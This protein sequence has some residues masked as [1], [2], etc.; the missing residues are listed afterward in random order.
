MSATILKQLANAH[1][2]VAKAEETLAQQRKTVS[3]LVR[4]GHDASMA[5]KSLR[6]SEHLHTM[7]I[8]ERYRLNK[9]LDENIRGSS[10]QPTLTQRRFGGSS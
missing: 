9:L 4:A 1:T 5:L 6:L 2:D 10:R 3:D 7:R 8:A